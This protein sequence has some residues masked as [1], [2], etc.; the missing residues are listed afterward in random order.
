MEGRCQRAP[1]H[2]EGRGQDEWDRHAVKSAPAEYNRVG[3]NPTRPS[4]I[5]QMEIEDKFFSDQGD[6]NREDQNDE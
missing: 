1:Q 3:S 4:I 5:L 6:L 2:R